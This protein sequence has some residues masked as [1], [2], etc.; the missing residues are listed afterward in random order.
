VPNLGRLE[1][2]RSVEKRKRLWGGFLT[3]LEVV[4]LRR[5]SRV[6]SEAVVARLRYHHA[7]FRQLLTSNDA[8]L[9]TLASLNNIFHDGDVENLLEL[10]RLVLQGSVAVFRMI[11]SLTVL[12]PNYHPA[13]AAAYER[14]SAQLAAHFEEEKRLQGSELVIDLSRIDRGHLRQ[15]GAKMANLGEVRAKLNLPV[16]D[17]F[18]VTMEA[19][20]QTAESC[21]VFS[22]LREIR[23]SDSSGSDRDKI[24]LLGQDLV[25]GAVPDNVAHEVL[26]AY[27][28]LADRL[29]TAPVVAVRSS[30][31]GEDGHFSHAGQ[32]LTA[33]G[34]TRQNLL[35][36]YQN[37]LGSLF[38]REAVDYREV[39][40]IP[41]ESTSMAVGV[42]QMIDARASGVVFTRDPSSPRS[43][44]LLVYSVRGLGDALVSDRSAPEIIT[45]DRQ[46]PHRVRNRK[47]PDRRSKTGSTVTMPG[48]PAAAD[49]EDIGTISDHAALTLTFWAL[50]MEKH[51]GGPQDIEWAIG[52][53][54]SMFILQSRPIQPAS[55]AVRSGPPEA[56][57][58]VLLDRGEIVCPGVG[59]GPAVLMDETGDLG[60]FPEGGILVTPRPSP[61]F[62]RVMRKA[63]AILS[64]TGST[65]GHMASLA[66]E[67]GVPTL[68][69]LGDATRKIAAGQIIT[70]DA[71]KG[72]VYSGEVENLRKAATRRRTP[73]EAEAV[74]GDHPVSTLERKVN[75]LVAHL[76]LTDPRSPLFK[77]ERC[78]S[79][80]DLARFVHEKCYEVMFRT[81][82]DLGGMKEVCYFLDVFLPIDLYIIDLGGGIASG[83][84]SRKV[85]PVHITSVP[86]NALLKGMLDPRLP[87]FGPRP[88]DVRG[89][90]SIMARHAVTSPEEERTFR[91]PSYVMASDRY[92][93]YTA[94]VGYHFSV[95]DTYCGATPTKNYLNLVFRGGAADIVRRV[96][97]VRAMANIL[98]ELG[99]V[100]ELDGDNVMARVAKATREEIAAKLEAIGRLFQFARQMDIAMVSEE[101]VGRFERAFLREDFAMAG[102]VEDE[103]GSG[104]KH[105]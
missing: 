47:R 23:V 83:L 29:G 63:A 22:S 79:L 70:V 35:S 52:R 101:A 24:A 48:T 30:A 32:Y 37:V 38:S 64:D 103:A 73:T 44:D 41:H 68:L 15:V 26:S 33:L 5:G 53:D 65:V 28:R 1:E 11:K 104:L 34:V 94:R 19:Y 80:H 58:Q 85:R 72:Y 61:K 102:T 89:F 20:R 66:R 21:G 42:I 31:T 81:G 49:Q 50:Q 99:F 4:G 54:G 43:D 84:T 57:A 8:F 60:A 25:E 98:R 13:L 14:I 45:V 51:F 2:T 69:E 12:S 87:R 46:P 62:V 40:Q 97:R 9:N 88:M 91:E 55:H 59:I 74:A 39:H 18:A 7:E 36:S 17:G 86:L 75:A 93:N 27:D 71:E 16:P 92:M 90:F 105:Q 6:D 67:L 100:V 56:S 82:E 3:F 78:A 77:A 10:E 95:V 96:R 76:T